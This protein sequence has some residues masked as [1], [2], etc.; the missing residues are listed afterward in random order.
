MLKVIAEAP[1]TG[2][3]IDVLAVAVNVGVAPAKVRLLVVVAA[4]APHENCIRSDC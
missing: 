3:L 4:T 1:A 2:T